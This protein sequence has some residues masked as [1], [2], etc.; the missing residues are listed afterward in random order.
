MATNNL[1]S[2]S[3]IVFY[4][5]N[6]TIK[7]QRNIFNVYSACRDIFDIYLVFQIIFIVKISQEI[8]RCIISRQANFDVRI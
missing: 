1:S 5:S 2:P 6:T 8:R 4:V 7:H 3:R